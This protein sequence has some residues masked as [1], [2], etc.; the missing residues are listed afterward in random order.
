MTITA[1]AETFEMTTG[2]GRTAVFAAATGREAAAVA[3]T[4]TP[5]QMG[6]MTAG[7]RP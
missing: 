4:V 1:A 5:G 3:V 7:S 6:A 2:S